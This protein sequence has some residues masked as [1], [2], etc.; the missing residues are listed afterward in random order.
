MGRWFR[1]LV[2]QATA[3][4]RLDPLALPPIADTIPPALFQKLG[5]DGPPF[6]APSLD[7]TVHFLEDTTAVLVVATNRRTP[8]IFT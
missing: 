5:P 8:E 4:G 6:H 1:Y 3:D 2:P 7:L